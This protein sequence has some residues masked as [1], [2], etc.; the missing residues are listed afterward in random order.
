MLHKKANTTSDNTSNNAICVKREREERN[1]L[2]V[3]TGLVREAETHMV[4]NVKIVIRQPHTVSAHLVDEIFPHNYNFLAAVL[5]PDR[6][7]MPS[8]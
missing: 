6:K 4:W 8:L 2:Q 3:L 1:V 7:T 5:D